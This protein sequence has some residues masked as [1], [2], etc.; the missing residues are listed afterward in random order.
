MIFIGGVSKGVKK[1]LDHNHRRCMVCQG[2]M[3]LVEVAKT[4]ELYFIPVFSFDSK[5]ALL[6]KRCSLCVA[7]NGQR[8]EGNPTTSQKECKDATRG[9]GSSNAPNFH[10]LQWIRM[11]NGSSEAPAR[12]TCRRCG[13]HSNGAC[14][15]CS[16]CGAPATDSIIWSHASE[17]VPLAQNYE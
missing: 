9:S 13:A 16:S 17:R 3:A 15:H 10:A 1:V 5:E 6:C 11:R 8:S 12:L 2:P 7:A 4:L 14:Q